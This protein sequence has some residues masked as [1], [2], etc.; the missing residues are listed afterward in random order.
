MRPGDTLVT[1]LDAFRAATPSRDL[2]EL[3]WLIDQLPEVDE[4]HIDPERVGL[5]GHS[6]GGAMAILAAAEP[7][8]GGRVAALVTWAALATFDRAAAAEKELWRRRGA[9]PFTNARTGQELEVGVEFL[10]DVERNVER[11]DVRR[12]AA[13]IAAPWLIVHGERDETVPMAEGRELAAAAPAADHLEVPGAGHTFGATHP[14][15]GPSREL[16]TAMNATQ[17]WFRRH[18]LS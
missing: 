5:F 9:F 4:R 13:R 11:L 15:A 14:L 12:A 18:L 2:D 17:T 6:R 7:R 1:D 10:D 8:L 3:L 16:I